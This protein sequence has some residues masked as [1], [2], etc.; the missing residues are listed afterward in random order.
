MKKI[1]PNFENLKSPIVKNSIFIVIYLLIALICW[2]FR[3]NLFL[4]LVLFGFS[5]VQ[6]FFTLIA[7][8]I[9]R[10]Y[11][12]KDK[13]TVIYCD[14]KKEKFRVVTVD[15]EVTLKFCDI[16]DITLYGNKGPGYIPT[17]S[18]YFYFKIRTIDRKE[19]MLTS[20]FL[21]I[22]NF[23]NDY[24]E[25][26]FSRKIELKEKFKYIPIILSVFKK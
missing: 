15:G 7:L 2:I 4:I 25:E 19:I 1:Y 11:Y 12:L 16:I 21:H 5:I 9:A 23:N 13:D 8:F 10:S 17:V 20:F 6:I 18:S 3:W 22:D 26:L 14:R 24:F